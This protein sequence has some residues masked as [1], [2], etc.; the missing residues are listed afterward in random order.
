MIGLLFDVAP[1]PAESGGFAI[2]ITAVVV[3]LALII[4]ALFAGVVLFIILRNR[5]RRKEVSTTSQ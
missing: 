1:S 4:T 5:G 3:I 2:V